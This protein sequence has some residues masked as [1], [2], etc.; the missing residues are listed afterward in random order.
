M[1]IMQQLQSL[2]LIPLKLGEVIPKGWLHNQLMIQSRGLSG[3]LDE[4]WPDIMD[5]GWIGGNAESWERFPY[6]L[7]GIVPLAYLVESSALMDKVEKYIEY[8]LDHQQDDGWLGPI[9]KRKSQRYDLWPNIILC[10]ALIQ[11]LEISKNE[12]ALDALL[13]YFHKL[14]GI[15]DA[16]TLETSWAKMRWMDAVWGIHWVID[17]LTADHAERTFLLKLTEKLK[18]QGYDWKDHFEDFYYI[19]VKKDPKMNVMYSKE[20]NF[21]GQAI[22]AI[23]EGQFRRWDLRSHVVNNAMGLKAP[24]IWSRQSGLNSDKQA[25][26]TAISNLDEHHGQATG[27]FSGDEHLAGKN[28]SQGTELCAIVEYLFSLETAVPII[29]CNSK[30]V[31]LLDRMEKICF[32]AL[33]AAFL[34][35]MWAH[36]YDQQVN[37]VQATRVKTP[38]YTTNNE[39]SNIY[40]LEPNFGCCTA[41]MHQGW[42]KFVKYGLWARDEEGLVCL[43]YSPCKVTTKV[44]VGGRE[45]PIA[46]EECTSYPFTPEIHFLF[47]LPEAS[48]FEVKFRIPLW[49]VG[50]TIQVNAHSPVECKTGI[51]VKMSRRWMDDDHVILRLPLDVRQ[52]RRFNDSVTILRGPLVFSYNPDEERKELKRDSYIKANVQARK[53]TIAMKYPPQVKDWEI[54][55]KSSWQFAV[56]EPIKLEILENLE[57]IEKMT[58]FNNMFPPIKIRVKAVEIS[59]WNMEFD[60]AMPPPA[61]PMASTRTLKELELIPYGC[62]NIRITEFP[63]IIEKDSQ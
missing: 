15:L 3:H 60:A 49:C 45:I 31:E 16:F 48:H 26:F 6:W 42:P 5:S 4:F 24:A 13:K 52:E 46:I 12:R 35:D 50:A 21:E 27:V 11:Y 14:D 62:T 9:A 51:F 63:T 33:P 8:I 17:H 61:N 18:E 22:Q 32:N 2:S 40:G 56:V 1:Y 47:H 53:K 25:L 7:D 36:Q 10:K 30:G 54:Y 20:F 44:L 39:E 38:I 59:N 58:V 28:P 57:N 29:G 55:P 43:C 23:P 37:Q 34:P 41:N 19:H